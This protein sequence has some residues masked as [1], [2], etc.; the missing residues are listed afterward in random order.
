MV[1]AVKALEQFTKTPDSEC[2]A[3]LVVTQALPEIFDGDINN[4]TDENEN[5][6][7]SR[8]KDESD[9]EDIRSRINIL[10][11]RYTQAVCGSQSKQSSVDTL[12]ALLGQRLPNRA[13]WVQEKATP[14]AIRKKPVVAAPTITPSAARS[15]VSG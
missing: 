8:C 5:M 3:L 2:E 12:I 9:V 15:H 10:S 7:P 11:Q 6:Y 4:P 1:A 13:D 14:A